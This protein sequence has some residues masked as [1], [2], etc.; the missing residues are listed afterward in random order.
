MAVRRAGDRS[1]EGRLVA[2]SHLPRRPLDAD[3]GK[4]VRIVGGAVRH[5]GQPLRCGLA[6]GRLHLL[7]RARV[8]HHQHLGVVRD[9]D[10]RFFQILCIGGRHPLAVEVN[11]QQGVGVAVVHGADWEGVVVGLSVGDPGL[12]QRRRYGGAPRRQGHGRR[13]I[14]RRPPLPEVRVAGDQVVH[15]GEGAGDV[16]AAGQLEPGGDQPLQVG[17]KEGQHAEVS[18]G[19][20]GEGMLHVLFQG[21]VGRCVRAPGLRGVVAFRQPLRVVG[22][23]QVLC[24]LP[25]RL[26]D[27]VV[28]IV[29]SLMDKNTSR[30]VVFIR[31][32]GVV[33][34]I[35]QGVR[36]GLPVRRIGVGGIA[37]LVKQAVQQRH[38]FAVQALPLRPGGG[39]VLRLLQLLV[40]LHRLVEPGGVGLG[41]GDQVGDGGL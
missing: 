20:A 27:G 39:G 4:A 36:L 19:A 18:P 35:H 23:Q 13:L 38:H 15:I 11:G 5:T 25:A 40:G 24:L 41:G 28:L 7:G 1:S 30:P 34:L 3:Q 32:A 14:E 29:E 2:H 6:G 9:L 16:P 31:D 33:D 8:S 10:I 37:L 21:V 17:L 26:I 22:A 12:R